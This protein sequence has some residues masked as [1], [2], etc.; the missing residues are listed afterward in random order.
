MVRE[1]DETDAMLETVLDPINVVQILE[2][3]DTIP[4]GVVRDNTGKAGCFSAFPQGSR[5]NVLGPC[6]KS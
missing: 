5:C 1:A 4:D 6:Y 2:T 3:P